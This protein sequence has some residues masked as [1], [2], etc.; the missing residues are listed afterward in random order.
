MERADELEESWAMRNGE[1]TDWITIGE[2]DQKT[3]N[4]YEH[5]MAGWLNETGTTYCIELCTLC[6]AIRATVIT[7]PNS[8]L[9]RYFTISTVWAFEL[10][11]LTTP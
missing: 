7:G 10:E 6:N 11:N 5:I 9:V 3:V 1:S 2:R 4:I 8:C